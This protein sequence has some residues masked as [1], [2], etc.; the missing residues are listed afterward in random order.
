[1]RAI[2]LGSGRSRRRPLGALGPC[3]AIIWILC[4]AAPSMASAQQ[5]SSWNGTWAGNWEN[6]RGTQIIFVGDEL[7]AV[8]WH[9]DYVGDAK[10]SSSP[11]GTVLTITWP[12]VRALLTRDGEN[13]AHIVLHETGQPDVSFSLKRDHS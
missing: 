13:A 1:M 7:I 5:Q 10:S 12:D 8:Y 9:D 6:G 3:L 11:D 2:A 4:A